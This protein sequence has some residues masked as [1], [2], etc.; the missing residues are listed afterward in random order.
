[1]AAPTLSV[2]LRRLGERTANGVRKARVVQVFA[3]AAVV[4]EGSTGAIASSTTDEPIR[5]GDSVWTQPT[6][7]RGG[8][9]IHGRA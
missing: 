3:G 7:K 1:M 5:A 6:R 8:I 2:V 9:V 4:Q